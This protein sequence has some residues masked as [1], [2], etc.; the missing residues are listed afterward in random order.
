MFS[1]GMDVHGMQYLWWSA[2]AAP[3]INMAEVTKS[4]EVAV[5]A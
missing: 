2:N 4:L 3:Y 5:L 1:L